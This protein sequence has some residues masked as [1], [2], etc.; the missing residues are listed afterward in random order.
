MDEYLTQKPADIGDKCVFFEKDW[1]CPYGVTC[2]F[3]KGH[4]MPEGATGIIKKA[5]PSSNFNLLYSQLR[6]KLVELP[7][8]EKY[9]ESMNVQMGS[10]GNTVDVK[11][12]LDIPTDGK[13]Y[14]FNTM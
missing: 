4:S 10:T 13:Y 2:R 11:T 7:R 1:E 12:Q 3:M 8:S 6:K 5:V 14:S 9:L